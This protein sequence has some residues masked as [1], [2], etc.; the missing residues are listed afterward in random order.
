MNFH[1]TRARDRAKCAESART[2]QEFVA[3]I[4]EAVAA[5]RESLQGYES[6]LDQEIAC[7]AILA[8]CR[9]QMSGRLRGKVTDDE[10]VRHVADGV[11]RAVNIRKGEVSFDQLKSIH[12]NGWTLRDIDAAAAHDFNDES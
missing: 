4:Y 10:F 2:D 3:D 12:G 7:T 8:A 5:L 9:A 11:A 6:R 1:A